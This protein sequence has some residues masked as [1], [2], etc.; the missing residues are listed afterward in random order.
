[1]SLKCGQ[2][3]LW[4]VKVIL[5]S[6]KSMEKLSSKIKKFKFQVNLDHFIA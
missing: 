6:L 3:Q 4:A 2:I 5:F 1:M